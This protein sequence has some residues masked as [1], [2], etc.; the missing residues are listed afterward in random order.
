MSK[1]IIILVTNHPTINHSLCLALNISIQ[2]PKFTIF[3]PC[4]S[5]HLVVLLSSQNK[6]TGK[7]GN[8]FVG[9]LYGRTQ[10]T[11][12]KEEQKYNNKKLAFILQPF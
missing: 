2:E 3:L 8:V 11:Y 7:I 9:L 4:N 10:G 5:P 6:Q 1:Q 12:L